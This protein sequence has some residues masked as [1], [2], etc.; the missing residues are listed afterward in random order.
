MNCA[1]YLIKKLEELGI[2]ELFGV[3]GDYNFN[4]LYAIEKNPNTNWIGCINELN[5]GYAADGYARVKGYGALVTTYGVGELSAINAVAG[6][7]AENIPV[8]SIVG[9]PPQKAIDNSTLLHH[10]LQNPNYKAFCSAYENVVASTAFI[11][12]DNAKMEIDR[13]FKVLVK[14][15]QPVYIAIPSDIAEM[16]ISDR[17]VACDWSSNKDVLEEVGIKISEKI[18]NSKN[19]II[20]GDSLIKRFDAELEYREFVFKSQ[21]PVTNFLMGANIV[22][23]NYEKYMGGYFGSLR[24]PIVNKYVKDTDC[25]ISVGVIYSDLNSFGFD[26]P[27]NINDHI[28]IYGNYTYI[29]GKRYDDVKMAD[30]LEIVTR[31]IKPK[32]IKIDKP[33]LGY[34]HKDAEGSPLTSDYI[35]PRIQEFLKENDILITETG[36]VSQGIAPIKFPQNVTPEFQTLWGSIGW[37]TPAAFGAAL[38]KPQARTVVVTGEGAHQ[39]S[40]MEIGSMM[41]YGIKPIIIVIN[42]GGYTTERLLAKEGSKFNDIVQM[43]YAKFARVFE[44]DVWAT[45]AETAEDF[46]KALKVTQIMNKLCYIEVS[47]EILDTPQLTKDLISKLKGKNAKIVPPASIYDKNQEDEYDFSNIETTHDLTN[48][49]YETVVHKGFNYSTSENEGAQ[50]E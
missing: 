29:N 28:A 6:S 45:K 32:D 50:N 41:R 26:L 44:G 20:I 18:N 2:T 39:I 4:L 16:E 34:K 21:I 33:N 31:N 7:M 9:L 35:Y 40:A 42:N 48:I 27:Y 3:A 36:I 17:Y 30:V 12:R 1:E 37:A 13:I 19:P 49:Q 15:K 5:A 23:M 25:A 10:N 43:N 11:T 22:D 14:N 8:V 46:D 47:T 38:A 24:N